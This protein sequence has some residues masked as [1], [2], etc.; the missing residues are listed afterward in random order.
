MRSGNKIYDRDRVF[1]EAVSNYGALDPNPVFGGPKISK[2]HQ[3]QSL[4]HRDTQI[5]EENLKIAIDLYDEVNGSLDSTSTEASESHYVLAT[6]CTRPVLKL[7]AP[8]T[9]WPFEMPK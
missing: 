7:R 6:N 5:P 3:I 4:L 8:A 2:Q 1:N 9:G